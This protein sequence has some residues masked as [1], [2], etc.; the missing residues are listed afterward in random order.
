MLDLAVDYIKDLQEQVKVGTWALFC[1]KIPL[2][3]SCKWIHLDT[4][5]LTILLEFYFSDALRQQI[6]VRVLEQADAI[7]SR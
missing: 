3:P 2:V 1:F 5:L 6:K 4:N 7:A